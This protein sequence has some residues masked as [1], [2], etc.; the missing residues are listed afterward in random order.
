METLK[1]IGLSDLA[2]FMLTSYFE[3]RTQYVALNNDIILWP[4][5]VRDVKHYVMWH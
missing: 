5:D 2:L 4:V 3:G 1:H